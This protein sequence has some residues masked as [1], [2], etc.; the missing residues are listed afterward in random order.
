EIAG[1]AGDHAVRFAARDHGGGEIV[2][3]LIDH[4][5]DVAAQIAA[6]LQAGVEPVDVIGVPL[7]N[8]G[9][10]DLN[11]QLIEA[12]TG[13]GGVLTDQLFAADQDGRAQFG[14]FEG[15]GGADD[16]LLLALGEDDALLRTRAHAGL[17]LLHQGGGRIDALA[18]AD[19]IGVHV[20]DRLAR[21]AG[22]H[23]RLGDEGRDV[24][25]QARIERGR[26]DVFRAEFQL[27]AAIGGGDLVRHV[28]A[29]Q[30]RQGVGAGD[31]HLVVDLARAHVQRAPEQIGE[32]QD[33]VDLVDVVR[34]AGGDDGVRAHR[35]HVFGGD[36]GI[37]V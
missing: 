30:R 22:V 28:L 5:L 31:L 24:P 7:G 14:L 33:V 9:V 35:H 29:G 3:V 12:Q 16:R 19:A 32:G 8:P 10:H 6:A 17:D 37:G 11:A 23:R 1:H 2:T 15:P 34:A 25:D 18:Q 27:A 36:L 20:L 4:A 13:L 26:D 21:H